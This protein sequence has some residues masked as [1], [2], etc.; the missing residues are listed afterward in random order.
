MLTTNTIADDWRSS[1]FRTYQWRKAGGHC[2]TGHGGGMIVFRPELGRAAYMK[3]RKPM[4]PEAAAL[5][6]IASDLAYDLEVTVPPVILTDPPSGW[7]GCREVCASLVMFG[8][9]LHWGGARHGVKIQYDGLVEDDPSAHAR[10][11][12]MSDT[13]WGRMIVDDAK[14]VAARAFVFDTWV[15]QPD[16]D[17]PSNI[18]WGVNLADEADHS[19]CFYDYEMAF[20]VGGWADLTPAPFP[21]EL[22]A[23][24]DPE[25]AEQ[26]LREVE[27]FPIE[28]ID[29]V[30]RRIPDRFMQPDRKENIIEQLTSRR[31]AVR[32]A[33][34]PVLRRSV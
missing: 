21:R 15:G 14:T 5:E 32:E 29:D 13:T 22:L 26:A 20:G 17:H 30:T 27:T 33:L 4:A 34:A 9:Q 11:A 18:A 2:R 31:M 3:P 16:H 12:I 25:S 7:N 23:H 6:K 8:F 1:A 28:T 10:A 24:L 19:L